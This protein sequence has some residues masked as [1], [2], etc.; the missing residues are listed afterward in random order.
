M[1]P[2]GLEFWIIACDLGL[3]I[4]SLKIQNKAREGALSSNYL[5]SNIMMFVTYWC[6]NFLI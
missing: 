3:E 1:G 2:V 6:F 5:L 4:F